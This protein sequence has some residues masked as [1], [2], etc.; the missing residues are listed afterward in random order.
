V[1]VATGSAADKK[2]TVEADAS[3][4][5]KAIAKQIDEVM[6][7][8]Q[9]IPAPPQSKQPNHTSQQAQGE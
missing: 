3:R 2:A 7:G 1:G 5:A 4:I 8:Q 9:W 6:V